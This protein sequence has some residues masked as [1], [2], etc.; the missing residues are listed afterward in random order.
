MATDPEELDPK[1][2][3]WRRPIVIGKK[4]RVHRAR[5]KPGTFLIGPIPLNSIK[6]AQK[7]G[8][9]ALFVWLAL[10]HFRD[11]R[12]RPAV[13]VSLEDLRLGETISRQAVRRAIRQLET[14]RLLEIERESG[15]LLQITVLDTP[16]RK[17]SAILVKRATLRALRQGEK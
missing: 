11:L 9:C 14:G 17:P 16:S 2:Y 3:A 1:Q 5:R 7:L 8:P 6:A 12:K 15:Q 13:R 4:S 10:R